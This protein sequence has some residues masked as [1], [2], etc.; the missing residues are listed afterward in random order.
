MKVLILQ[1]AFLGDVILCSSLVESLKRAGHEVGIVV[2]Q[3][4]AALYEKDERI[5]NL[6]I[7]DK[8]GKDRG[9]RGLLRLSTQ[10]KQ[11][12]YDAA[13]IPHRSFRSAFL[14]C[15][16][17]VPIRI[18]FITSAGSRL[19]THRVA[20]NNQCHEIERNHELLKS[21]GITGNPPAPHITVS[22]DDTRS[23]EK[24]F[25][26]SGIQDNAYVIGIGP[27]SR[28]F[29]KQWGENR[30]KS[31]ASLIAGKQGVHCICFGGIDEKPLCERICSA[32]ADKTCNAAGLLNLRESAAAL[33]R[34]TVVVTNDNGFMHLAAAS[35]A[36][37]VALFGPTVPEFG[38]SPWGEGHAILSK[39]V[40]CRPCSI[41]GSKTCPEKH[42]RCMAELGPEEVF[43]TVLK[44]VRSSQNNDSPSM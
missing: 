11:Q 41:H 21:L 15:M 17:G 34:V 12:G 23:A 10:L 18:G 25:E 42:F 26:K 30:F 39:E 14:V 33:K 38:F 8:R 44:Y 4:A 32:D 16:A 29:T 36:R 37:V 13:V 3:E 43:D 5:A 24:F 22:D 28:W 6:H 19:F 9:V 27:G 40:Y 31:L 35:G 7:F 1:T 2:K 20:Y